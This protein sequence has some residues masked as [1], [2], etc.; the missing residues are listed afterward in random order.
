M[1]YLALLSPDAHNSPGAPFQWL[2]QNMVIGTLSANKSLYQI[3]LLNLFAF[4]LMSLLSMAKLYP[5][6]RTLH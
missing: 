4:D 6:E 2:R 3:P 5:Y 1:G